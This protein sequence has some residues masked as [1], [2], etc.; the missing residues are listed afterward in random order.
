MKV[1]NVQYSRGDIMSDLDFIKQFSKIRI[2][3]ICKNLKIQCNNVYTG[4]TKKEN[5]SKVK[6]EI[7]KQLAIL[8][9]GEK[10]E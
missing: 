1:Q 9:V 4:K 7:Y 6:N 3:T 2:S 8:M 10:N 5:I